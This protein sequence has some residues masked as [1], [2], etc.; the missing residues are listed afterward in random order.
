MRLQT[1]KHLSA[2]S[3]YFIIDDGLVKSHHLVIPADN[4]IT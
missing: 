3:I 1:V 4:L 2:K